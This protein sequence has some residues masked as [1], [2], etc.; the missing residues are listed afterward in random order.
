M[1]KK[2]IAKF[3]QEIESCNDCSFYQ[4][5]QCYGYD[6]FHPD[7]PEEDS[8]ERGDEP[9]AE[10]AE[11]PFPKWCPFITQGKLIPKGE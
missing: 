6:C 11:G 5:I 1:G 9:L 3:K 10:N 7:A 2:F 8:E 4:Y